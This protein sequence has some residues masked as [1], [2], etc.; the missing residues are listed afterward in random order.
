MRTCVEAAPVAT[1]E[2]APLAS[3]MHEI[4][5]PLESLLNILYLL[6]SE[7]VLTEHGREHLALA[8]EEVCRISHI[9]HTALNNTRDRAFPE[10]AD[11]S[12]LLGSVLE[13]YNGRLATRGITVL[14]RYC[15]DGNLKV[16]IGLLRQMFSNLLLNAA[17]AMPNGGT[18]H[19]RCA[20]C[21][22]WNDQGRDG[23]R[24]TFADTGCGIPADHLPRIMEPFF[25]TKGPDGSGMGLS[26]V[27]D[28]V[29]RHQGVLRIRSSTIADRSGSIFSIFLPAS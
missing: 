13:L 4:N 25:S 6:E 17:D 15:S 10:D 20:S 28:A 29:R 1:D 2:R 5:N 12:M 23:I 16:H 22:E 27:A 21:H 7:A 11:V 19:V 18:M 24:V 14:T 9:A 3:F 26:V 8:R